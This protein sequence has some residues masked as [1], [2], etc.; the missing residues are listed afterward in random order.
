MRRHYKR[1]AFTLLEIL[2]VAVVLAIFATL[3]L[4]QYGDMAAESRDARRLTD[5]GTFTTALDVYLL[6]YGAQILRSKEEPIMSVVGLNSVAT[7]SGG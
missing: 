4:G 3:A 2:I 5:F 6:R 7:R 1:S